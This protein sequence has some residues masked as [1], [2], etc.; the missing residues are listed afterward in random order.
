M[1]SGQLF[2]KIF[3]KMKVYPCDKCKIFLFN[4]RFCEKCIQT[5]EEEYELIIQLAD[6]RD[7][8][9]NS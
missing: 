3:S 7:E 8:E 5:M 1:V 2:Y 9:E 6:K 4:S